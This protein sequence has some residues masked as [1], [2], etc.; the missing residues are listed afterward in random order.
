[1]KPTSKNILHSPYNV[2]C[3]SRDP[4]LGYE[5]H[6]YGI[7]F[8]LILMRELTNFWNMRLL[9]KSNKAGIYSVA[10]VVAKILRTLL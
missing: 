7:I 5:K 4:F 6:G 10:V 8:G 3:S 9:L 2:G 1:M